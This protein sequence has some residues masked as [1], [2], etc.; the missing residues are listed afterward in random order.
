MITDKIS[1]KT[2]SKKSAANTIKTAQQMSQETMAE[3]LREKYGTARVVDGASGKK[4]KATR[5]E[6]EKP[7]NGKI[8][9][10][11]ET[12]P[13]KTE[14]NTVKIKSKLCSTKID[15]QKLKPSKNVLEMKQSIAKFL[16]KEYEKQ[17]NREEKPSECLEKT[18][19]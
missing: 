6:T 13:T 4:R 14:P 15:Q 10:G 5:E 9:H 8:S 12:K 18:K 1:Q 11:F 7:V 16:D 17:K 19:K 2:P 3:K